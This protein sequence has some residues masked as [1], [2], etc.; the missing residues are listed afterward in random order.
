MSHVFGP[1][2]EYQFDVTVG[3]VYLI[4]ELDPTRIIGRPVIAPDGKHTY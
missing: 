1:G 3:D 2:S 4:S